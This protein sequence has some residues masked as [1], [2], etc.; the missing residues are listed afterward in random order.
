MRK[1]SRYGLC[2]ACLSLKN[3]EAHHI[4]PQRYE[5]ATTYSPILHCCHQCHR[6]LHDNWIDP[7]GQVS[8]SKFVFTTVQFLRSKKNE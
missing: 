6:E 1:L 7:L 8:R 2:P 4:V 3:L 5:K